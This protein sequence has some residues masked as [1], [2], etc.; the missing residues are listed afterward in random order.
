[1]AVSRHELPLSVDFGLCACPTS[2]SAYGIT[3]M[4]MCMAMHAM[5]VW[6]VRTPMCGYVHALALCSVRCIYTNVHK[7]IHRRHSTWCMRRCACAAH[8]DAHEGKQR[9]SITSVRRLAVK[10]YPPRE[11]HLRCEIVFT[12]LS[13]TSSK[14]HKF[15]LLGLLMAQTVSAIGLWAPP[16]GTASRSGL[17]FPGADS[18]MM[19]QSGGRDYQA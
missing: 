2:S 10:I 3:C 18:R 19:P 14:G 12:I 1:M 11:G 9:T 4:H 17:F 15:K 8:I 6:C 16:G 13:K 7:S 5:C